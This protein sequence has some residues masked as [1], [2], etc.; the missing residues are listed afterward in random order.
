M[1]LHDWTRVDAGIFHSHHLS[2]IAEMV[3]VLNGGLLP[4]D[5]YA[6]AEPVAGS[7]NPDVLVLHD[8]PRGGNQNGRPAPTGND[9]GGVALLTEPPRTR[10]VA[11]S[12]SPHYTSRQRQI[13]IR[14]VSDDRIVALVEIVSAGN[15]ASRHAWT[16]FLDKLLGALRQGIHLLVLDLYPPTKRDPAGV[17]GSVWEQHTGEEYHL[18][19]D[20][21]R[22]LV[23]YTA[24]SGTTAFVEPVAVHHGLRDMPLYLTTDGYLEV[25]LEA[26]YMAAYASTPPKYRRMLD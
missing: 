1:P 17:H 19:P 6:L 25:P 5:F 7:G 22:T 18:P 13:A 24:G 14:H 23:A 21:D 8:P 3:K 9:G 15:K 10:L 4:D 20:A 2:W 12:D 26:T 11:R 16:T